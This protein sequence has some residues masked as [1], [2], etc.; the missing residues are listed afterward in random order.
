MIHLPLRHD[1]I[2]HLRQI[3]CNYATAGFRPWFFCIIRGEILDFG[4]EFNEGRIPRQ[5]RRG[6][7]GVRRISDRTPR[8]L[9]RVR[10]GG[11][12][13]IFRPG[14]LVLPVRRLRNFN[15]AS[16]AKRRMRLC[17]PDR[18]RAQAFCADKRKIG[19]DKMK[20]RILSVLLTACLALSLW[21]TTALAED[22]NISATTESNAAIT[23]EINGDYSS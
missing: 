5:N 9:R 17:V 15:R 8:L 4:S 22:Y 7:G 18:R 23:L 10:A 13:T 20:K 12:T 1:K 14:V 21:P 16:H 2:R 11:G 19:G 6:K 3:S